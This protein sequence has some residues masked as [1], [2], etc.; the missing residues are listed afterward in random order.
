M[1]GKLV[2][3]FDFT[4]LLSEYFCVVYHAFFLLA[5]MSLRGDAVDDGNKR[6]LIFAIMFC[7]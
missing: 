4:E 6:Q 2:E 3:A 7:T 5:G 1:Y